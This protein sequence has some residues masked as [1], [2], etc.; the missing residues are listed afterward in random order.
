MDVAPKNLRG[1]D[2]NDF[3]WQGKGHRTRKTIRPVSQITF[4]NYIWED[5]TFW[6]DQNVWKEGP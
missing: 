2:R 4:E 3:A 1:F 6:N 5:E